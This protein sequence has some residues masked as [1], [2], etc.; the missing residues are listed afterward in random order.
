MPAVPCLTCGTPA[1]RGIWYVRNVD[2]EVVYDHET[3]VLVLHQILARALVA[4]RSVVDHL[5]VDLAGTVS[6]PPAAFWRS[7]RT[8]QPLSALRKVDARDAGLGE[9]ASRCRCS[10]CLS[11]EA[12]APAVLSPIVRSAEITR[13]AKTAVGRDSRPADRLSIPPVGKKFFWALRPIFMARYSN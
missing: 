12:A 9:D 3:T 1:S 11:S 6:T 7:M 13:A 8:W 2:R 5:H 4:T 10:W